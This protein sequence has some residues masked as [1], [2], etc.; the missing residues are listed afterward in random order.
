V[1]AA[2][3]SAI[4]L[5][6]AEPARAADSGAVPWTM[7]PCVTVEAMRPY[8][9]ENWQYNILEGS[10]AQCD[11]VVEDGGFRIATYSA[12]EETGTAPGYNV[13]LFA[14]ATPGE[15]RDFAVAAL[16]VTE[17]E[18][19]VCVLSGS[20]ERFGCFRVE[21]SYGETTFIDV[22]SPLATDDPL[23]D[24][25]VVTSPFTGALGPQ[26]PGGVGPRPACGTCF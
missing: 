7:A 15:V 1:A 11:P 20:D 17:G 5:A 3:V 19:G 26:R 8:P 18:Y 6:C 9:M 21:V 12:D 2:S 25:D 14:S 22:V 24:K 23:V 13:R 16:P 10:V 4:L